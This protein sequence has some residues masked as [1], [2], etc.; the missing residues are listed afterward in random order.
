MSPARFR[1]LALIALISQMAIAV[2]GA[3]V[4]LT[5]SGLGCSSWPG[6]EPGSFVAAWEFHAQVEW[7]NRLITGAVSVSAAA[8]LIGALALRPRVGLFVRLSAVL[9][10]GI[11]V[12]ALVGALVTKS[13]LLPN[14]VA[15]HFLLSAILVSLATVQYVA[16]RANTELDE[17]DRAVVSGSELLTRFDRIAP[18]RLYLAMIPAAVAVFLTGPIVTGTGPH[19]GD[20]NAHRWGFDLGQITR[21]HSISVWILLALVLAAAYSV[22]RAPSSEEFHRL[23]TLMGALVLQGAVGYIQYHTHL[24]VALVATHVLGSLLVVVAFTYLCIGVFGH[25]HD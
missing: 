19:A 1:V 4:R 15:V 25:D 7:I 18:R 20:E 21:V 10:A 17:G 11:F 13:E 14:W 9:V 5:G 12:Q 24:P 22:R 2:T 6:C 23:S 8:A 3:T 16:A